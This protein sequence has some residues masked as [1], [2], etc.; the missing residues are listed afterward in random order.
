MIRSRRIV[1]AAGNQSSNYFKFVDAGHQEPA[2]VIENR[3]IA[4]IGILFLGRFHMVTQSSALLR[5]FYG[6]KFSS[7]LVISN[8]RTP[9]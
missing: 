1:A 8:I 7:K 9:S 3:G 6:I 4:G 2:R 5:G